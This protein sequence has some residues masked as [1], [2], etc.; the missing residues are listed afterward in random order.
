MERLCLV[1]KRTDSDMSCGKFQRFYIYRQTCVQRPPPGPQ[2][3][4]RCSEVVAAVRVRQK[5][6]TKKARNFNRVS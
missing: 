1:A 2:K 6:L 3:G 4:G 5:V